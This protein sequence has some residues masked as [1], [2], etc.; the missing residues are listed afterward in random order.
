MQKDIKEFS[1]VELKA[2]KSDLYEQ[3]SVAQQNLQVI[4]QELIR[5]NAPEVG[6]VKTP[7]DDK[8]TTSEVSVSTEQEDGI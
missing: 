7:V 3:V 1:V 4:Q 6:S 5:R 2:M 8:K